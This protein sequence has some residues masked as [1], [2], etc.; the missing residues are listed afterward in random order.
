MLLA[1]MRQENAIEVDKT[2]IFELPIPR[3]FE[4]AKGKK[5]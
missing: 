1:D 5:E 2:H 3:E 4:S